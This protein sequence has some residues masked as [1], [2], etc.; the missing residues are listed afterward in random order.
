M[1]AIPAELYMPLQDAGGVNVVVRASR[2]KEDCI[3][4][5]YIDVVVVMVGKISPGRDAE[6]PD[7]ATLWPKKMCVETQDSFK[8]RLVG[9]G[10]RGSYRARRSLGVKV[11]CIKLPV[12][13][14]WCR[15]AV[16]RC[17]K[18]QNLNAR[19]RGDHQK[20]Q[21]DMGVWSPNEEAKINLSNSSFHK[22]EKKNE[23]SGRQEARYL[24]IDLTTVRA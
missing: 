9:S 14:C 6:V 22:H 18:P 3:G 11:L 10:P 23:W 15:K 19:R 4:E 16:D 21:A 5:E 20:K 7:D 1:T 13:L 2:G 17:Y 12:A 8:G 24:H